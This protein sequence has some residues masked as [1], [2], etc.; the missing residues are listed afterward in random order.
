[1][2]IC[3]LVTLVF[4]SLLV[5]QAFASD[6]D[7]RGR[8]LIAKAAEKTNIFALPSFRMNATVRIDN[9][10]KPLEGTYSLL[11]NGPDQWREEI[12]FPGY[13]EI[14]VGSKGMVYL[15][16]SVSYMPY[17]VSQL[18][19]TLGFN[20]RVDPG[21]WVREEIKKVHDEKD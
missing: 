11:W 9:M 19:S 14:Q 7:S 18:R 1:M 16:R 4:T 21:P 10:G 8:D 3:R 5:T 17:Q 15:K 13:S 20:S 12:T 6:A 2:K